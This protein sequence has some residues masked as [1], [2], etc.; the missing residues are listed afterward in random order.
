[1]DLFADALHRA[2]V[3]VVRQ[4]DGV[5]EIGGLFGFFCVDAHEVE[6]LPHF[7]EEGVEIKFHVAADHDGVGFVGQV[8][9]LFHG[10]RVD[11]VVAVQ[12][13]HVLSVSYI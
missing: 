12:A 7:L 9:D 8:V 10:D 4:D 3:T 5:A 1:M 11:L 13:A 2:A 6:F